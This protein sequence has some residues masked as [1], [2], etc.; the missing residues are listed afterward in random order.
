VGLDR[1]VG[2]PQ[3]A[4]DAH[5]GPALGGAAAPVE[6]RVRPV[7]GWVVVGR[8]VA[9]LALPGY[10]G[11]AAGGPYG[12]L[13]AYAVG[14][15]PTLDRAAA[16]VLGIGI[17]TSPWTSALGL[18]FVAGHLL[19]T[20][21]VGVAA[22]RARALPVWIAVGLA[23]SQPIHL[24]SVL[25]GIR[26]LDLVGWGS[27]RWASPSPAGGCCACTPTPSTSHRCPPLVDRWVLASDETAHRRVADQDKV[28]EAEV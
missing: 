9:L 20:I 2:Q 21:V 28:R 17:E 15:D 4:G 13:L 16:Q 12:D 22:L 6:H 19:G 25:T 7:A 24:T 1:P 8:V 18:I 10:L 23:V 27:P 11:L 5:V 3:P 14:T 26:E